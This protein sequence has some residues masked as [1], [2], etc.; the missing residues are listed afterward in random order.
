MSCAILAQNT[1]YENSE[2]FFTFWYNGLRT[3]IPSAYKIEDN[4]LVNMDVY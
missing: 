2:A 1:D 3:V 4:Y